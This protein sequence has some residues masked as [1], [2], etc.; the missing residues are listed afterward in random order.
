[1]VDSRPQKMGQTALCTSCGREPT[2]E[3]EFK[4]TWQSSSYCGCSE[5][6]IR[7]HAYLYEAV[8]HELRLKRD[9]TMADLR[10]ACHAKYHVPIA[11]Q[12][13]TSGKS[14]NIVWQQLI[15]ANKDDC[16]LLDLHVNACTCQRLTLQLCAER[17][18]SSNDAKKQSTAG[19]EKSGTVG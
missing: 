5:L 10:N 11:M 8:T 3:A 13:W 15:P 18:D 1:M 12:R 4:T 6:V 16:R 17:R 19:D 2:S 9:A 14:E 7:F